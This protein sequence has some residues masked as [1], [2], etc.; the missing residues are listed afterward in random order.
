MSKSNVFP[1]IT[2]NQPWASW[3]IRGWKT[4]ETRTHTKFKCLV[5]H[6][7]LIHAG[8][9]TDSK[10][11]YNPYLTFEQ[12]RQNPDEMV[13]GY[14]IGSAYVN[15]FMEL[16]EN[17]SKNSLIDCKNVKRYG[18]FLKDVEKFK[19]PISVPGE[20]GVWYY[21]LKNMRKSDFCFIDK[22]SHVFKLDL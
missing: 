10:A 8:L 3:I 11:L 14:I 9:K 2:L 13:N 7:V 5:G 15:G 16:N 12:I 20:L 1:A 22:P 4:I 18:L 17:H 19:N 21:D 6:R